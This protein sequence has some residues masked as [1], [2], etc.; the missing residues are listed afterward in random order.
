L[1]TALADSRRIPV[2]LNIHNVPL[3]KRFATHVIGM[4]DGVVV[5][6]GPPEGLTDGH[7]KQIYGGE[8]WL[9]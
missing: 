3:A 5:Y 9:G 8:D 4:A 6:D 7:L 2:I 1:M